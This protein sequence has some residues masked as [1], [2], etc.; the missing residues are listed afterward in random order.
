MCPMRRKAL[1]DDH[2]RAQTFGENLRGAR[3]KAG[4]S[5]DT[6]A[7]RADV[8][9]SALSGYERG[10]REP[11]LRTIVKLAR[12]LQVPADTLMRGL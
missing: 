11:N 12:A 2:K 5:Q 7:K 3:H 8:D 6:L 4:L 10:R 9:R 1:P